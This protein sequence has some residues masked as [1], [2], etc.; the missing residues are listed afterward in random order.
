MRSA[1]T[2]TFGD[3]AENHAG[4]QRLGAMADRGFTLAELAE[5]RRRFEALGYRCETV[6]LVEAAGDVGALALAPAC[7][8]IVRG[9]AGAF[10]EADAIGV[11]QDDL[12]A[13]RDTRARMYGRVVDKKARHNLCFGE[14]G[15]E[16]DYEAGRGRVVAFEDVP[17]LCA[18]RAD[19]PRFFGEA[20]AG[21]LAEGN[22]YYDVAR[23]GIG[24]HG[25]AERR[26]VVALR[27][28]AAIPLHF[29]WFHRGAP[30][31]L[32]V[33]LAL[34][35]GDL[36]CLSEKAVGT[37]WRRSAIPTLRHAAGCP[38]FLA[39]PGHPAQYPAGAPPGTDADADGPV[40]AGEDVGGG[41][42]GGVTWD[43]LEDLLGSD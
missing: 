27:F 43:D 5:A 40:G 20:A 32:R 2:V 6:D 42:L 22:Y 19:L 12:S 1:T 9:G 38:K 35:H 18:V 15:Q 3:V 33:A 25:D 21:L 13:L 31:G 11:E 39:V 23:C 28:G 14:A 36:Y 17:H 10:G 37:D 24:F 41:A 16:P 30:V 4:M 34:G 26:R 29:Q 8:L 7:V